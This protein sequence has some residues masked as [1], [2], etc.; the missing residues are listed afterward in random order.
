MADGFGDRADIR[1]QERQ[2]RE[3]KMTWKEYNKWFKK[4]REEE[5]AR[6]EM[7]EEGCTTL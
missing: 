2:S 6:K 5:Q 3:N 7:N 1:E 4:N